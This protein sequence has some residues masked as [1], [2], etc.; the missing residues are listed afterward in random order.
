MRLR[1]IPALIVALS[2][3]LLVPA[4]GSGAQTSTHRTI[5]DAR[6]ATANAVVAW[7][8]NAGEA[9][10]A[11]CFIGGYGPQEARMYAMMHIAIHDA[12]NGIDRRYQPYA[13]GLRAGSE[14]S[15]DAAV[16]SAARDVL[17]PVLRS[18]NFFLPSQCI[19]DGV[20]SVQNDYAAALAS[21][22]N[23]TAKA[24]GVAL[25]RAAAAAI[26]ARRTAD[27]YRTPTT[28]PNYQEGTAPGEYRYTPGTPFAFAPHL[29]RDLTP[30]ALKK[31]SQFRP[32]PPYQ[33]TSA[34]YAADVN[35]IKHLGGDDVTTPSD[36]TPEQ[37]QIALFWVESSPLLW[38]RIARSV[39]MSQGLDLW[40]SARL[41][42][43]LNMGL[44]DGYITSF[45]T[46]YHYRFWRPVTAI[47]LAN[48]DGNPATTADR[49]WTPLLPTPPIPDY[50]SGHAVE[51]GVAAQVLARFLH[52]DQIRFSTCSFTLP[53]GTRCKDASPTRRHFTSFSQAEQENAVSRIY[54]GFHFRDAVLTGSHHGEQVG[55]WT[56]DHVLRPVLN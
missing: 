4:G 19:L 53:E 56:V 9:S 10:V 1:M 47:R 14:A 44:T 18:L 52:T 13:A 49:T 29:G 33:L 40:E 31:G 54:V 24:R 28:D 23:G 15:P 5:A 38:N 32:G 22:P 7:N 25:G 26:L 16:A 42:G 12:L 51:G 45:E 2:S 37:T 48:V 6:A 30:F 11:A 8:A 34:R 39:S 35:E 21:I 55:D 41:F 3:A 36:R 50:D 20:K 43:L 17:V 27:G 46:K